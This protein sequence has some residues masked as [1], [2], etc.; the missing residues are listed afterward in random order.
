[1]FMLDIVLIVKCFEGV[2]FKKLEL[3]KPPALLSNTFGF[4][5]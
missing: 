2:D 5:F 4:L 3:L 1:M